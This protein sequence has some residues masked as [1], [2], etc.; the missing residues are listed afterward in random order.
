[1]CVKNKKK[2]YGT[3][4]QLGSVGIHSKKDSYEVQHRPVK[5]LIRQV[6]VGLCVCLELRIRKAQQEAT[7]QW[8][9]D[10]NLAVEEF[11]RLIHCSWLVQFQIH[12]RRKKK[13]KSFAS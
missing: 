11:T 5:V 7:K 2:V 1:M 13:Q 3:T 6:S 9:D 8:D 12:I 10:K 4:N